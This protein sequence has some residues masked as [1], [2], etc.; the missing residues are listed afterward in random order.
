MQKGFNLIMSDEVNTTNDAINET[1]AQKLQRQ[2]K[3]L[4][5]SNVL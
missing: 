1:A 3:S 5:I 2:Q 4:K